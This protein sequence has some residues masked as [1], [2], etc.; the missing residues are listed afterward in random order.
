MSIREVWRLPTLEWNSGVVY[1]LVELVRKKFSGG[2]H[3]HHHHHQHQ[4]GRFGVAW[5]EV[6]LM[7]HRRNI[8]V[9]TLLTS[10][11]VN[12]DIDAIY[13]GSFYNFSINYYSQRFLFFTF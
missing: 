13:C 9:Q 4:M 6:E 2:V 11:Q 1:G 12:W 8:L 3:H 5:D 10:F 7:S